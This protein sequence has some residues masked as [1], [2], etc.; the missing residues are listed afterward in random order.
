MA[1]SA[2]EPMPRNSLPATINA[3]DPTEKVIANKPEIKTASKNAIPSRLPKRVHTG[4]ASSAPITA[5]AAKKTDVSDHGKISGPGSDETIDDR[6]IAPIAIATDDAENVIIQYYNN[7]T[8][9]LE[10][11]TIISIL[12]RQ[13]MSGE[14]I[15][16]FF[17]KRRVTFKFHYFTL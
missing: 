12:S 4:P 7:I 14:N 1:V 15:S 13:R 16:G 3:T 11:H 9:T 10:H 6:A 8:N 2:P 5:P 17:F